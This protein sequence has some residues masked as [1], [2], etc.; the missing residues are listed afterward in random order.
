MEQ[1]NTSEP[2]SADDGFRSR[3]RL[4]RVLAAALVSVAA[5]VCCA[6]QILRRDGDPEVFVM[7]ARLLARGEDIFA[8]PTPHGNFYYYPPFFAFL[9]IPL[10]PLPAWAILVLWAAVSVA[11]YGWSMAAFYGA[12][13][14]RP[15]F[16]L[17]SRT[18]W[19]VC[20][21]ST[22]LTARFVILHLRF[23]QSNIFVLALV[24][25]GL[26]WL[27][28]G[29]RVSAG[30]ATGLSMAVKLT[31]LPFGFW[32][33][34]RRGW[35]VLLG[36]AL[37]CVLAALLPALAVGLQKDFDYHREWYER[38][39]LSNEAG[40]GNWSSN[41][42]VSL[43]AQA[44]RF[45]LKADAFQ[46]KGTL[47]RVTLVELPPR[48]VRAVGLL[49]MLFVAMSIIFYAVRYRGA[50]ELVSRWGGYALVF[51]LI[52]NF[53]TVSEIP[54]LV[55]LLPAYIYVVH[56]WHVRRLADRTFRALVVLS[57]VLT[58]L[59]TQTFCGLFLSRLLTSLGSVSWGML[60]L[61]AAIF[62]AARCVG[63]DGEKE[64]S[65]KTELP[66]A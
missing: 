24:V 47:Y 54:H 44:D 6:Q 38:V 23:G 5:A 53:S 39:A 3:L 60:L 27:A 37:G 49:L 4:Y 43:R 2:P 10:T 64:T 52:P 22:A 8:V 33:L 34:A 46:Y 25:L 61:S 62:R 31:T 65:L 17:P 18:R 41:G 16:S 51:S 13:N 32:F 55:L 14:G 9:N 26:T 42:N 1:I 36:V 56:L 59:T 45:F 7:A 58:T 63:S 28:R 29:R 11:L 57:F 19:V 30:L 40:T 12:M 20:F 35:R 50:P 21:F 15:F 48:A 66:C